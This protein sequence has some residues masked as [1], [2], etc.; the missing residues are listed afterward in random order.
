MKTKLIVFD[1]DGTLADTTSAILWTYRMAIAESGAEPRSDDECR[2]TIGLP[3]KEGFRKLY[4]DFSD[5]ELD[6]CTSTYRR[7]FNDNKASL[8][9]TLFPGVESTLARLSKLGIAMSIASSRSYDSL[10]EFCG[11]CG[12]L[13][14]FSLILGADSVT[15]AKPS[16]EP[17][18][19][20]LARLHYSAA[21]AIVVG[22]MPVDIAMGRG[23][24][25][26]TAGVTY[27]NSSQM[28]LTEAGADYIIDSFPQLLDIIRD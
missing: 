24:Q 17:V 22:D 1:F 7:I 15:K 18:L 23:A 13:P 19:A 4:P 9:P 21:D 12:I 27:G 28:E 3:L 25:C 14:Y 16:P 11:K 20:T 6:R 5:E 10:A 8:T 2:A 26:R